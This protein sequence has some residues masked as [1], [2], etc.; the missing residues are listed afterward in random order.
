MHQ[1]ISHMNT[2][3]SHEWTRRVHMGAWFCDTEH[4]VAQF[5]DVESFR[6]HMNDKHN[7]PVSGPPTRHQ[8]D[9]L[10][11]SQCKHLTRDEYSCPFCDCIL[12]MPK[13]TI[14]TSISGEHQYSPLHEHIA[15]HLKDLAVLCIP[16]SGTTEAPENISDNY[17]AEEK[18]S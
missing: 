7:H 5:N 9:C 10:E 17:K 13:Q 16:I 15:G 2:T 12:D 1:R 14:S 4:D 3:H 8:L 18:R 11:I 6:E